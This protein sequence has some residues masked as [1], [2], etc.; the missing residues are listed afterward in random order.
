MGGCGSECCECVGFGS[1]A[2]EGWCT[3]MCVRGWRCGGVKGG[4]DGYTIMSRGDR[5]YKLSVHQRM[6]Y[7]EMR[8]ISI[9]LW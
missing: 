2:L 9:V 6:D 7:Q 8:C 5:E 1:F 3:R 4:D